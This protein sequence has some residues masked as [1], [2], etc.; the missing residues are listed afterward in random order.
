MKKI[1][2]ILCLLTMSVGS[3]NTSLFAVADP[4]RIA[5]RDIFDE[6]AGEKFSG[7]F[8]GTTSLG[9]NIELFLKEEGEIYTGKLFY[10]AKKYSLKAKLDGASLSGVAESAGDY[11]SITFKRRASGYLLKLDDDTVDMT[12]AEFPD[13]KRKWEGAKVTLQ[14]DSISGDKYSG[15]LEIRDEKMSFNG[16]VKDGILEGEIQMSSSSDSK[17]RPFTLEPEGKNLLFRTGTFTDELETMLKEKPTLKKEATQKENFSITLADGVS[18]DMIRIDPG[19]FTMGSPSDELGRGS[20][21]VQY[22]VTLTKG[23]WLGQYEITQAQYKAVMKV[24]PSSFIG[25]DL[26]VECVSWNG[27]MDFCAKLTE[28]E[29]AAGRLPEGSEYTLPTEAQWEYACRAG[30]TTALNSGKNLSDKNKC[31]EM[32]EVGWYW[33]NGGKEND[34]NG[35]TCT[36]PVGQK[37]PNAWGLYDMHGNVWEWCLDWYKNDYPASSVTDPKGA[38]TG[39]SRVVRGGSWNSCAWGCRSAYRSNGAPGARGGSSGFRVCLSSSSNP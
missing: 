24:N 14:A 39:S 13:L 37:Q 17:K 11:F 27:A 6:E 19:T 2:Y 12:K 16:T 23:Y 26:P 35:L 7:S 25:A 28:I 36:H 5:E 18:L 10:D 15:H 9:E 29:K 21:E 32:D 3:V 30:T 38:G 31:P 34:A 33:Y 22:Q 4:V 1:I 20:N 8:S